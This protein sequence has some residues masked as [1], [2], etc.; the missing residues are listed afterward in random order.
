MYEKWY[1]KVVVLCKLFPLKTIS[2]ILNGAVR[3]ATEWISSKR[4][5]ARKSKLCY[6]LVLNC[7]LNCQFKMPSQTYQISTFNG[8]TFVATNVLYNRKKFKA[9]QL[10]SNGTQHVRFLKFYILL[11]MILKRNILI[12][13]LFNIFS[14][15]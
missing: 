11:N 12:Y 3:T 1:F 4:P 13:I 2:I 7:L 8:V 9:L 10:G 5:R 6:L 14:T 15:I